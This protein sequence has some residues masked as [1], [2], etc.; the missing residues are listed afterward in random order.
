MYA[1][2]SYYAL[3]LWPLPVLLGGSHWPLWGAAGKLLLGGAALAALRRPPS[4]S[5]RRFSLRG[6]LLFFAGSALLLPPLLLVA[7][8]ASVDRL[9]DGE[10]GGFMRVHPDGIYMTER[11]YRRAAKSVRLVGM[12][13]VGE[14]SYNF[15]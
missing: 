5:V 12:V 1:I 15:V 4:R 8:L 11:L 14:E 7:G 9:L 10:T 3:A 2:R 13:H 6:T